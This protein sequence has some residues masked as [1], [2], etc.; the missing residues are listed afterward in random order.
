MSL[1]D[2]LQRRCASR[3]LEAQEIKKKIS[4]PRNTSSIYSHNGAIWTNQILKRVIIPPCSPSISSYAAQKFHLRL[5]NRSARLFDQ[6]SK[7]VV[8]VAGSQN[9]RFQ[10]S[11]VPTQVGRRFTCYRGS[12]NLRVQP[13]ADD[14]GHGC[15][16]PRHLPIC[17]TALVRRGRHVP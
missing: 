13:H 1:C 5:R 9:S 17:F 10:A 3:G 8:H 11:A 4:F 16:C 7:S 6:Y 14:P 2:L 12:G 15:L